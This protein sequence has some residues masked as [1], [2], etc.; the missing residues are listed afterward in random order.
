MRGMIVGSNP[1]TSRLDNKFLSRVTGDCGKLACDRI[2]PK[3]RLAPTLEMNDRATPGRREFSLNVGARLAAQPEDD[4]HLD[5]FIAFRRR[6]IVVRRMA[7][8]PRNISQHYTDRTA[9][10]SMMRRC[11]IK[12][13]PTTDMPK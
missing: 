11:Q 6:D 12:A 7:L 4:V 8:R 13:Q 3:I 1:R 2:G 9:L 5:D 10:Q